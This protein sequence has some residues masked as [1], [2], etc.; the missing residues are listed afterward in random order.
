MTAQLDFSGWHVQC[1]HCGNHDV[2]VHRL[3]MNQAGA[4]G[5]ASFSCGAD[6]EIKP[7]GIVIEHAPCRSLPRM[8]VTE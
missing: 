6:I 4:V 5:R 3:L 8:T 7:G 2:Q 1:P